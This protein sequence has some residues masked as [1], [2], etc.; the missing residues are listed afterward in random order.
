MHESEIIY[1]TLV[2]SQCLVALTGSGIENVSQVFGTFAMM[3]AKLLCT[4]DFWILISTQNYMTPET[5]VI[6]TTPPLH[7]ATTSATANTSTMARTSTAHL[8]ND[9]QNADDVDRF[10]SCAGAGARLR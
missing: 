6:E 5:A 2:R 1:I 8:P 4:K 7:G 9:F 3:F 10:L